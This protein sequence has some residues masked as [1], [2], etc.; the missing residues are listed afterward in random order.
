MS[1]THKLSSVIFGL[2][3]TLVDSA[4]GILSSFNAVLHQAGIS[5]AVTLDY[6]IIGPPLRKTLASLTGS[7]DS[8]LL[9]S[10]SAEFKD[11]YDNFGI[12]ETRIYEGIP[13]LLEALLDADISL[14]ICTNKRLSPSSS[15]LNSMGWRKNFVSLYALDMEQNRFSDKASLLSAQIKELSLNPAS[16]IFVGDTQADGIASKENE[17]PFN[18]AAWGYGGA[19]LKDIP[20]DWTWADS[21]ESLL[22]ALSSRL[23]VPAS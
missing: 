7:S 5:P 4:P 16:T 17:I 9:D 6:S 2:D 3:G 22:T 21:P 10:L 11:H 13:F 19:S 20:I 12:L 14:H 18:Y 1:S 15:I 23:R 8:A